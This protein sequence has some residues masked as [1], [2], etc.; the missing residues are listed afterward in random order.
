MDSFTLHSDD[1]L[2]DE[3]IKRAQPPVAE[4]TLK[5]P[6]T[7]INND[8]DNFL[9]NDLDLCT[10]EQPS[11]AEQQH[12]G[13]GLDWWNDTPFQ[14]QREEEEE[15]DIEVDDGTS[16]HPPT[17]ISPIQF[18][19]DPQS[20]RDFRRRR[21]Q[22]RR[23]PIKGYRRQHRY[24]P[25]YQRY[26]YSKDDR[27]QEREEEEGEWEDV[28][29]ERKTTN[30]RRKE[31]HCHHRSS[32][33]THQFPP[34]QDQ[35][36]FLLDKPKFSNSCKR[37]IYLTAVSRLKKKVKTICDLWYNHNNR[38]IVVNNN[39]RNRR[40]SVDEIINTCCHKFRGQF[41]IHETSTAVLWLFMMLSEPW[42]EEIIKEKSHHQWRSHMERRR[43]LG[44]RI[45][46][47]CVSNYL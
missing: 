42:A 39:N 18:L 25:Y 33:P 38:V 11:L 35:F 7:T 3:D 45:L 23:F 10:E 47:H 5:R 2:I 30:Q 6:V 28:K 19:E 17:R 32:R 27:P 41:S 31:G 21:E 16:K 36:D 1:I 46:S 26:R 12:N 14:R 44:Q 20:P 9:L 8:K 22:Q 24:Q 13:Q 37:K 4:L 15:E 34:V 40:L 43:F 29:E